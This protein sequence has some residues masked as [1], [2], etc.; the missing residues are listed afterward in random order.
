MVLTRFR[1]ALLDCDFGEELG[2]AFHVR[3][4]L[5]VLAHPG[6]LVQPGILHTVAVRHT[7]LG[8]SAVVLQLDVD[9]C[10]L[11]VVVECG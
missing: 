7:S 3:F 4:V 8:C 5:L 9:E 6:V 2:H 1:R 10:F 11:N